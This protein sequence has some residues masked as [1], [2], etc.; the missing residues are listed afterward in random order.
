MSKPS[1]GLEEVRG[2][3]GILSR[4]VRSIWQQNSTSY[5]WMERNIEDFIKRH[6][7]GV[8]SNKKLA[9]FLNKSNIR[10]QLAVPDMTWKNFMKNLRVMNIVRLDICFKV[11]FHPKTRLPPTIV[12]ISSSI[13]NVSMND[14]EN[15]DNGEDD[16]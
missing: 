12:E 3:G 2:D 1:K 7:S 9:S 15:D 8:V 5:L 11:H 16:V 10:S 4:A 13:T 6:T 14:I